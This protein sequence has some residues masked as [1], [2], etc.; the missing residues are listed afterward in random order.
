MRER[1]RAIGVLASLAMAL[2][3]AA[4][5]WLGQAPATNA[6]LQPDL[7]EIVTLDPTVGLDIRY[8][9]ANNFTGRILYKEARAFLQ[10]PAAEALVRAHRALKEKGLGI[11]IWDAYRPWRVTKQ[12]WDDTPVEK[13]E[14]V[15][16]PKE[17]SR[18][19]RGC[20][21][22]AT[23]RDLR[24]GRELDMPSA[25]DEM[26][27]AAYPDYAGSTS[28]ARAHRD[29]LRT[30]MENEGFKVR[31]NEWWHFDFKGWEDYPVLDIEFSDIGK[32]DGKKRG[33]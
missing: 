6:A 18:H 21:V 11:V 9:T 5:A 29:L 23:L 15:A 12:L 19:N 30:A 10:R 25:Y 20:A 33:G 3:W 27:E 31:F 26:G 17:G 4:A 13:R 7:V 28:E 2:A 1:R 32:P 22:D 16:N 14:F 24:T 8:A